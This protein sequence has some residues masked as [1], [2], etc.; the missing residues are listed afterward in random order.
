MDADA[1]VKRRWRASRRIAVQIIVACGIS[2]VVERGGR[3][4]ASAT[5]LEH[6]M[7]IAA[8]LVAAFAAAAFAHAASAQS[9]SA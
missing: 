2:K 4:L 7:K 3:L 6:P 1:A 9:M 5:S 8:F